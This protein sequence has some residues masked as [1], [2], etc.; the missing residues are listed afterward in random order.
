M[1][2]A[3]AIRPKGG[4]AWPVSVSRSPVLVGRRA[5][6]ATASSLVDAAARGRGSALL[7]TG[8]AGVGKSRLVEEIRDRATTAG[9]AVCVGRSVEG[10][11]TY[12]AVT[13]ALAP[14]IRRDPLLDGPGLR[15]YRTALSRLLPGDAPADPLPPAPDPAVMIGEGVLALL[16]GR[17]SLLVLEDLHWAD[18]ATLA[19]LSHLAA[20][21]RLGELVVAAT[22]RS[23]SLDPSTAGALSELRRHG[24]F[25]RLDL[26]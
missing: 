19:L 9:M 4:N 5:E 3:L 26:T 8:E 13:E 22:A 15:P 6:L 1:E 14:L 21:T 16:A 23:T 2:T 25:R 24:T 11:G 20:S 12:R 17:T 18:R 7:I 10:G